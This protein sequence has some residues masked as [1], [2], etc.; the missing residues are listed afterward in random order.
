MPLDEAFRRFAEVKVA[1]F[2]NTPLHSR[3]VFLQ[4]QIFKS[5]ITDSLTCS[6]YSFNYITSPPMRPGFTCRRLLQVLRWCVRATMAARA[7]SY[8]VAVFFLLSTFGSCKPPRSKGDYSVFG[9][10][11]VISAPPDW[12]AVIP[13]HSHKTLLLWH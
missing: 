7:G 5:I 11:M 2:K 9:R 1:E 13:L 6:E 10:H 3:E 4:C 12:I 8:C